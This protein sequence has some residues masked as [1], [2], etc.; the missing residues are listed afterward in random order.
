MKCP[1]CGAENEAG[2][3]FCEQCGSRIEPSGEFQQAQVAVAAQPTA[4][5]PTCPSCGAAVLPGEAFCDECGASLSAAAPTVIPGVS[6]DAPTMIAPPGTN[7]AAPAAGEP[8]VICAACGQPN[9]ATDRFCDHC[10]A[11]LA[12]PVAGALTDAE[13]PTVLTEPVTLPATNGAI[14]ETVTSD[15]SAVAAPPAEIAMAEAPTAEQPILSAA[16]SDAQALYDAERQRLEGE[17]ARQQQVISQLEPVQLALGAATPAGVAQSIEQ[18]RD[19]K[20]KAEAD[21]AGLQPPAPAVDPAEIARLEDEIARQQ[22]VISQLEPVQLALGAATPAGVAQSIEQARDAKA[23]AEADLAT[24]TGGAPAQ[25]AAAPVETAPTPTA[26]PVEAAP[27]AA[28][29]TISSTPANDSAPTPMETAISEPAREQAPPTPVSAVPV[30]PEPG[31]AA[32]PSPRLAMDEGN[33]LLLPTDKPEIIVGREDP[34]SGIFPEIDLT[35]YGGETGGVS[36]QHA[37]LNYSAGQ[38]TVT[39]LNSTN[40]TRVDGTKIEPNVAT[41]LK[42]GVRLQFGR[43]AMTFKS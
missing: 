3:R 13:Q 24:L 28:A 2:N 29:P 42:D 18:A 8:T 26:A 10:G 37:R 12:A 38:W 41:A 30:V 43:V 34:I 21:L 36:R 14:H 35:P 33:D 11:A 22:Q 7:A 6:N 31:P 16:S 1:T 27:V 32:A 39:D 23:K 5:G 9:L 4:A 15:A 17:I 25:A 19:A 40:Y 20:S